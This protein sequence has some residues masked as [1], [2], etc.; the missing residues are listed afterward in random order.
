MTTEL[1]SLNEYRKNLSTIWKKSQKQNI[2]YIVL[3]HSKPV[4]EVKPIYNNQIEDVEPDNWEIKATNT[5]N[6]NKLENNLESVKINLDEIK[7]EN[8]FISLIK[9][10]NAKEI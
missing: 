10:E 8:D 4:M 7:N 6:K 9:L 1:I 5:Y 3:V 2:K